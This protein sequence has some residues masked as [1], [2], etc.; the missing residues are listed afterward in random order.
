MEALYEFTP[1]RMLI[2]QLQNERY[3]W[4]KDAVTAAC[5]LEP[6]QLPPVSELPSV[7]EPPEIIEVEGAP[8]EASSGWFGLW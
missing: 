4:T 2:D 3:I 1:W 8:A 6:N 5:Q 7:H